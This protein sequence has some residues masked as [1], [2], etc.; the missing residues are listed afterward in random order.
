MSPLQ[1]IADYNYIFAIIIPI[2]TGI[3]GFMGAKYNR[4]VKNKK[5]K[6]I[7]KLTNNTVDI[8]LPTR[9]GEVTPTNDDKTVIEAEFVA[10]NDLRA[11]Y[12]TVGVIQD[13]G[14]EVSLVSDTDTLNNSNE[15]KNI[16]CIGGPVANRKVASY[17]RRY[18]TSVKFGMPP[19][20]YINDYNREALVDFIY[21]ESSVN[22]GTIAFG[23]TEFKFKRGVRGG[24]CI[25]LIRLVGEDTFGNREHGTVHICFGNTVETNKHAAKCYTKYFSEFYRRVKKIRGNYFIVLKCTN[26]GI[27]DFS[28]FKDYIA[29]VFRIE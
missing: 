4:Y 9:H 12:D 23:E 28:S 29:E 17:F 10:L 1:F 14:Y 15:L 25:I 13:S 27:I 6:S 22:V 3:I 26:D 11:F 7:L 20:K 8:I 5:I 21:S 24:G 2:A 18:F 16:F 19:D